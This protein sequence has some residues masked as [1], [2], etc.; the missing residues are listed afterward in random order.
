MPVAWDTMHVHPKE[1][2]VM[3]LQTGKTSI[4]GGPFPEHSGGS[5]EYSDP[6]A[7]RARQMLI[8][9]FSLPMHNESSWLGISH[10]E[11]VEVLG[12]VAT[13]LW[14]GR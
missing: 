3:K 9:Y 11:G 6:K 14:S 10:P 2:H 12:V 7:L 4:Y 8:F 1:N 13:R 5:C